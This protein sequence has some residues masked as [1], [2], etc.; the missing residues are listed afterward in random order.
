MRTLCLFALL[1]LPL[2]A[3]AHQPVLLSSSDQLEI[4]TI[5]DPT[6]SQ[7][8]Y[9]ELSGWPH[10]YEIRATEPFLLY[11]QILEPD[12]DSAAKNHHLIVIKERAN[13]RG[14]EEV[15]RLPAKDAD[16]ESFYEPF[17]SDTYL[18]GGEYEAEVEP[19]VYRIEVS[20]PRNEGKYVL[21]VGK[22]EDFSD[23]GYFETVKRIY[24]VKL[25]FEK[26]GIAVV[27]SPFVY[28]PL[29]VIL[30]VGGGGYYLYRRRYA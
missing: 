15:V 13:G 5:A 30:L 23:L 14:V 11:T 18:A 4:F 3:S 28:V 6:L 19:G 25:F 16:W 7:A 2:F 21:S 27:L 26:P 8:F 9:G 20:T 24:Q 10:T 29:I 12:I 22:I 1:F 17:G